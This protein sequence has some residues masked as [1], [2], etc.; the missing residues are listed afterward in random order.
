MGKYSP[1]YLSME[2]ERPVWILERNG[3]L[4]WAYNCIKNSIYILLF[5]LSNR[6][7]IPTL[8]LKVPVAF[9]KVKAAGT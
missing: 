9:F 3:H 5:N 8:H 1:I 4:L 2:Q 7:T 6:F